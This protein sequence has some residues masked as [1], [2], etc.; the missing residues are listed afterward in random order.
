MQK[1]P[2]KDAEESGSKFRA[3]FDAMPQLGWFARPDG[4]IEFYNRGWYEYTGTTPEQMEG[5]GWRSVHDPEL[6]PA[7]EQRWRHSIETGTTFELTFPLRRHDGVFRWFLTRVNPQRDEAGRIIRWVGINT[8]VDDQRR[9][10][11]QLAVV[12][13]EEKGARRRSEELAAE[14]ERLYGAA[15]EQT[16]IHVQLN[17]ALR[18]ALDAGSRQA[19][20][21]VRA[22]RE[23]SRQREELY[24]MWMQV[25]IPICV[26]AGEDLVYELANPAYLAYLGN[27]EV[28]GRPLIEAV[29]EAREQGY[30]G[31]LREVMRTGEPF[32]QSESPAMI[33]RNGTQQQAFFSLI[34]SV[35]RNSDGIADRV[36][37]VM[38]DV[39]D[40]VTARRRV[41]ALVSELAT[42][43]K[44]LEAVLAQVRKLG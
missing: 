8:D 26:L 15:R 39:T 20:E 23:T 7:V 43:K 18:E 6:L 37:A 38:S 35:I 17:Q 21:R 28:V 3:L 2:P 5:W 4:Y 27:R 42:E 25:P 10:E 24:S 41:E 11:Q 14:N 33:E 34:F 44:R 32:V 19:A 1:P 12:L 16:Q 36:L 22:E 30:E 31:L 29:P 40:Q 9:S 13:A